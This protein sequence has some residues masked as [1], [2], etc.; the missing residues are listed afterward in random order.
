MSLRD[1]KEKK[2]LAATIERSRHLLMSGQHQDNFELLERAVRQFPDDPEIRLLYA[3]TLL[4]YRV[5]DVASEACKAAEL[6]PDNPRILVRAAHLMLDRGDVDS[7][8]AAAIRADALAQPDF[9]LMA[10]L[11]NLKGLLA[12]IDGEDHLAEENLRSALGR[13][14]SN[15]PFAIDLARHLVSKGR[16]EE[17]VEVIDQALMSTDKR[18]NLERVRAEIAETNSA[19]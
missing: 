7:A 17:A 6:A 12:A 10:D 5:D 4:E 11:I 8:R 19:S 2:E 13:Q 9:V 15:G 16:R 14:P 3:T 1:R 18:E